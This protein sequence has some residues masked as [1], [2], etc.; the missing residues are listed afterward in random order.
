MRILVAG[1]IML[2]LSSCAMMRSGPVAN[3]GYL[4]FFTERSAVL[5]AEATDV[6]ARAAAAAKAAPGAPVT[7]IGWTDSDGSPQADVAL[8]RARARCVADALV[9]DGVRASRIV[10]QGRGQTH[11]D[12]GVESRRVEI[13]VGS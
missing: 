2:A 7:V 4:V 8:S 1:L 10:R 13:R 6:V 11:N 9:S 12:S 5:E 3:P